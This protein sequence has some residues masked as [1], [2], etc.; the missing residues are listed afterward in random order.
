MSFALSNGTNQLKAH[1]KRKCHAYSMHLK[2]YRN[3]WLPDIGYLWYFECDFVCVTTMHRCMHYYF[4]VLT[5]K[6]TIQH[7]LLTLSFFLFNFNFVLKI[8]HVL[9]HAFSQ[10]YS[11][12]FALVS[13]AKPHFS[14]Y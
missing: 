6:E 11:L 9:S 8:F 3:T 10:Y 12:V 2:S 7:A 13:Q 5:I 4:I 1:V 14:G